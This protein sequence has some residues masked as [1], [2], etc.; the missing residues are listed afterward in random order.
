[1][2]RAVDITLALL[3]SAKSPRRAITLLK[4]PPKLLHYKQIVT[5]RSRY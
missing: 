4:K 3:P 2:S 1:M 5:P